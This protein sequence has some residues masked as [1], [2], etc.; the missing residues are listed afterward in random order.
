MQHWVW[1]KWGRCSTYMS[2]LSNSQKSVYKNNRGCLGPNLLSTDPWKKWRNLTLSWAHVPLFGTIIWPWP[3]WH[4]P[5][6]MWPLT[7]R[8]NAPTPNGFLVGGAQCRLVVHNVVLYQWGSAQ[9]SSHKPRQMDT[10]K[11]VHKSTPCVRVGSKWFFLPTNPW[12][13]HTATGNGSIFFLF[14]RLYINHIGY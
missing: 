14:S 5:W 9:C 8:S 2:K 7:S 13:S 1:F 4:W 6:P 3:L 10:Q 11:A 12:N